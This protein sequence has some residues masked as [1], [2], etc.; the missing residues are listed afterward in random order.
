MSEENEWFD[1]Y[2]GIGKWYSGGSFEDMEV[3]DDQIPM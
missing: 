3:T 1:M 2:D